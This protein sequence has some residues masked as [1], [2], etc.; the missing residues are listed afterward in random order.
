[1][2]THTAANVKEIWGQGSVNK[3][4]LK[5][6]FIKLQGGA[7]SPENKE[8]FGHLSDIDDDE[9]TALALNEILASRSRACTEQY[10]NISTELKIRR[11][12][13]NIC[14]T[15]QIKSRKI[16]VIMSALLS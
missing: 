12:W 2:A 16:P 13:E 11:N 10:P 9:L 15:N 3:F 5:A 4:I 8:G 1:M 14:Y 7:F 6:L